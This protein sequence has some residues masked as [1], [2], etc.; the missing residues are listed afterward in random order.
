MKPLQKLGKVNV[1]SMTGGLP[2]VDV[3][4]L[5]WRKSGRSRSPLNA[6]QQD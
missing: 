2:V 5:F 6:K 4:K 3:I 1:N